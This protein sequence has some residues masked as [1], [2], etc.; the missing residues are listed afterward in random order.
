MWSPC[1]FM[2]QSRLCEP[3]FF[4]C[5]TSLLIQTMQIVSTHIPLHPTQPFGGNS[6]AALEGAV[7]LWNIYFS[8]TTKISSGIFSSESEQSDS[9]SRYSMS[10]KRSATQWAVRRASGSW[11]QQSSMEAHTIWMPC[12]TRG[13]SRL[14]NKIHLGQCVFSSSRNYK[15]SCAIHRNIYAYD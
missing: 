3:N 5:C 13:G 2:M 12:K 9:L 15:C 7:F 6:S 1:L 14:V 8:S 11:S 4:L 10:S